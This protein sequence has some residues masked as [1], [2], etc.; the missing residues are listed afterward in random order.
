M[1]RPTIGLVLLGLAV[2][3]GHTR[4]VTDKPKADTEAQAPSDA[5]GPPHDKDA[6][7]R[8]RPTP[9]ASARAGGQRRNE[10][11]GGVNSLPLATSPL[12]LLKPGAL[13]TIQERLARDGFLPANQATG[14][15]DA[16]T[17]AALARFQRQHNLPATGAVDNATTEKLGLKPDDV[18]KRDRPDK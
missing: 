9:V 16:A 13:K 17:H 14:E 5:A 8:H 1:T 15:L 4:A 10:A 6:P 11:D 2:G 18:F 7:A 12:A 3:C